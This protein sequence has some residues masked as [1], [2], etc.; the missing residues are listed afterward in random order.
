MPMDSL[1]D[2]AMV[3]QAMHRP[4]YRSLRALAI[5]ACMNIDAA[6]ICRDSYIDTG[7]RRLSRS[8]GT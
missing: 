4:G 8:I 1:R 6:T 7:T 3:A 5:I 2:A